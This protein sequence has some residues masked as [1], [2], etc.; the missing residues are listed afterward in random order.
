MANN[1]P[2]PLLRLLPLA[3]LLLGACASD[4]LQKPL[5]SAGFL[6]ANL[7]PAENGLRA[8]TVSP[9]S[10]AEK[11]RLRDGDVLIGYSGEDLAREQARKNLLGDVRGGAGKTLRLTVKRDGKTVA[12]KVVPAKK[13]VYPRDELYAVLADEILTG[14]NVSV[15]VIVTQ[16]NTAKPEFFNNAEALAAWKAGMENSL[17]NNFETLLL[18]KPFLRCGTYSVADRDKTDRVLEEARFPDDRRRLRG[19]GQAGRQ[20]DGSVPSSVRRF[21]AVPAGLRRLRGRFERAPRRRGIGQRAGLR[22]FPPARQPAMNRALLLLL[23]AASAV[24]ARAQ[25]GWG[26]GGGGDDDGRSRH[27]RRREPQP[28]QTDAYVAPAAAVPPPG[29]AV[30]VQA[31]STAAAAAPS[32]EE[33]PSEP[34]REK[35]ARARRAPNHSA[36]L[37]VI[38]P[39]SGL[40]EIQAGETRAKRVY[41]HEKNGARFAHYYD[42]K[43]HWYGFYD[44]PRF[45]WSRY[46]ADRWWWYDAAVSRW[47]YWNDGYWWWQDPAAPRS[48]YLDINDSLYAYAASTASAPGVAAATTAAPAVPAD[49]PAALD[50]SSAAA[51][52]VSDNSASLS[53]DGTRMVQIFGDRREAFLYERSEDEE[54]RVLA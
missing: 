20:D 28:M 2:R 50:A 5:G 21:H 51:K 12:L 29:V 10:P 17:K 3:V 26:G 38:G 22:P 53:P 43:A 33:L 49:A 13:D 44:G 7:C 11:A 39:P 27:S 32:R 6:G 15:A 46:A 25:R 8:M 35:R 52:G 16:V 48:V 54:P 23:L 40:A 36:A 45:Y 24:P 18:N 47:L 9:G 14:R 42:G 37:N 19:D 41:W 4:E 31:P 1:F 30:V 34:A